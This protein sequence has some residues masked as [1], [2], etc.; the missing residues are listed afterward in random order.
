MTYYLKNTSGSTVNVIDLGISLPD[1]QSLV[2]DS[3]GINAYLTTDMTAAI[4][5]GDLILSTTDIGDNGGDMGV[6]DAIAAL[7][8]TSRFDRDNPHEV[9]ITQSIEA[10][11]S[12]DLSITDLNELTDGGTTSLHDHDDRYY[13]ET[14]LGDSNTGTV[15][16]HWDNITNAPS[17]GSLEWQTPAIGNLIGK[18]T[19][20]NMPGSVEEGQFYLNEDDD[21]LYRYE[22]GSWVDQGTPVVGDRVIWKDGPGEDDHIY[23]WT[24]TIWT[25]D[26][27]PQDNWAIMISDDGDGKAAQYV[28]DST[29]SPPD[30]IKIADVD[31]GSHNALAG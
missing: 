1:A 6:A 2:I 24:G 22:S 14:E 17:F 27:E 3:N 21:H 26:P 9:T 23:E 8:I 10:D 19:A 16:V 29:G 20:A 4:T 13:T 30:W 5:S 25:P 11:Q 7:S 18:G 15:A 12:T 28:Y 31:W